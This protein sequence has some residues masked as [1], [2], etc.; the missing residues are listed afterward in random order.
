MAERISQFHEFCILNKVFE[1]LC[2]YED[3]TSFFCQHNIAG[4]HRCPANSYG[5]I[6]TTQ[7][8]LLNVGWIVSFYPTIESGDFFQAFDIPDRAIKYNPAVR[9]RKNG[10]AEIIPD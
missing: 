2:G 9:F 5:N 10:I 6:N 4:Q 3:D 1:K 8:H 7:H